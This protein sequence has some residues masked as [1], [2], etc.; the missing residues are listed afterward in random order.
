MVVHEREV[1]AGLGRDVTQRSAVKALAGE[2]LL[3]GIHELVFGRALGAG[4]REPFEK[5]RF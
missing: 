4:H 3:G 5:P 2:Q 1:D